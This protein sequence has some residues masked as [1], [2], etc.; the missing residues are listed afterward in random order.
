MR[1]IDE[2]LIGAVLNGNIEEAVD[3]FKNGADLHIKTQK[4]YNL[5][6]LAASRN[7][8]DMFDWLLDVSVKG[9]KI[10]LNE[11]NNDGSTNVF[12]FIRL[13]NE[14][15]TYFIQ[16]L[17]ENG[18][19]PDIPANDGTSP[20]IEACAFHNEE[21]F[22][23]LL[24]YNANVN[25]VSPKSKT[26]AFTM[27]CSQVQLDLVK[28]L[29]E[30]GVNL[31][32]TDDYGRNA[33]I[34]TLFRGDNFLQKK[35][36]RDYKALCFYLAGLDFDLNAKTDS[37]LTALWASSLQFLSDV[38]AKL[39]ERGAN[40]VVWHEVGVDMGRVSALHLW[41]MMAK[42]D[43]NAVAMISKFLEKGAKLG[44]QDE[45][46][47]T[48]ESY[49]FINS[50]LRKF[51][52]DLGM[53]VNSFLYQKKDGKK[54]KI[55]LISL[56][57]KDG[58]TQIE[59]V[60]EMLN[61]GAKISFNEKVEMPPLQIA[62]QSRSIKIIKELLK[63][64]QIDV[65]KV[66]AEQNVNPLMLLVSNQKVSK[67]ESFIASKNFLLDIKKAKE[68]GDANGVKVVA[69]DKEKEI[70]KKIKEIDSIES[71]LK[72]ISLEIYNEL[73]NAGANI[74][75]KNKDDRNALFFANTD[76]FI[77]KLLDDGIDFNQVDVNGNNA[78]AHAMSVGR[79]QVAK[80]IIEWVENNN[81]DKTIGQK[82]FYDLAFTNIELGYGQQKLQNSIVEFIKDKIDTK[83][84]FNDKEYKVQIDNINYQDEDG[85]SPLLVACAGN[86]LFLASMYCKMGADVN[87]KNKEDETPIMHAIGTGNALMVDFLIK[88]GADLTAKTKGGKSVLDFAEETRNKEL[89]EK[90]K[91]ELENVSS[92]KMKPF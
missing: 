7:Q 81:K 79:P 35:E 54:I 22:D 58:D 88:K 9:E 29:V 80:H 60:K 66:F 62:I 10:N 56:A 78:V 12:E 90:I 6:Y 68:I 87:L 74:N 65:N 14:N 83:A 30:K 34:G 31:N 59:I 71:Q 28:K 72:D 20:L 17:L 91:D 63:T 52:L 40:P 41:C 55:P 23:L 21:A 15:S 67:F 86:M 50:E 89:I 75:A 37:G 4:G 32:H 13:N 38:T 45:M 39:L 92:N 8:R 51:F 33:L 27:A 36:K 18:A 53:D 19:N 47:N 73:K 69:D 2:K 1:D 16:K 44:I 77:K 43:L 26:T 25:Y 5:L 64:N 82:V 61:K 3:C 46:G 57:I 42:N 49:A 11:T 76:Y 70:D 48:P 85:N 84:F 24:Q